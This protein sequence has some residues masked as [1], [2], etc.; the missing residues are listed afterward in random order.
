MVGDQRLK[1][2]QIDKQQVDEPVDQ[3]NKPTEGGNPGDIPVDV[4]IEYIL[5]KKKLRGNRLKQSRIRGTA[6]VS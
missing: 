4:G 1:T 6:T 3:V 5:E 2:S